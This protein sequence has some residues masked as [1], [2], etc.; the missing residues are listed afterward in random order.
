MPHKHIVSS[1][2]LLLIWLS[3]FGQNNSA[4]KQKEV[5]A[6][7]RKDRIEIL[8][9]TISFKN[10]L[11]RNLSEAIIKSCR[12][13]NVCPLKFQNIAVKKQESEENGLDF[14]YVTAI[15][16]GSIQVA[17]RLKQIGNKLYLADDI[18]NE[19]YHVFAIS[20]GS[21]DCKLKIVSIN[22]KLSWIGVVG[23]NYNNRCIVD[24]VTTGSKF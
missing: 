5:F 4:D 10:F 23:D 8:I 9:D 11:S 14:F 12:L 3:V 1:V 24:I 17:R 6:E 22:G 18:N 13:N 15:R 20:C 21:Q 19:L 7:I 2:L 16:N